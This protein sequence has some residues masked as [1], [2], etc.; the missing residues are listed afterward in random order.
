LALYDAELFSFVSIIV[1]FNLCCVFL[2]LLLYYLCRY[3]AA[4]DGYF[5]VF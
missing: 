3:A 5:I 2:V 4:A 1:M